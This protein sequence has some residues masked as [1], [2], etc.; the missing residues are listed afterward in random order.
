M[1]AFLK[2]FVV[3]SLMSVAVMSV[4]QAGEEST[5]GQI[6][7][8]PVEAKLKARAEQSQSKSSSEFRE[9][10]KEAI[11]NLRRSGILENALN[12]GDT[13]PVF[14]LPDAHGEMRNSRE[15]LTDGRMVLVF[16]RGAWCP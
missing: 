13:M 11:E 16:Y 14:E 8:R 3:I 5:A 1:R 2:K 9:I 10:S 6:S 7:D 12:V 4:S 15:F